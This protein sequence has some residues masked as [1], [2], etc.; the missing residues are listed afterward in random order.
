MLTFGCVKIISPAEDKD[1]RDKGKQFTTSDE[2]SEAVVLPSNVTGSYLACEVIFSKSSI[3]DETTTVG[4]RLANMV[5]LEKET[6]DPNIEWIYQSEVDGVDVMMLNVDASDPWHIHYRIHSSELRREQIMEQIEVGIQ[7][8]NSGRRFL[9]PIID[10]TEKL[11][12][13]LRGQW[14]QNDCALWFKDVPLN[15]EQ[16][17]IYRAG[18][19]DI[20]E[21][22]YT[23]YNHFYLNKECSGIPE[24][25]QIE[26]NRSKLAGF[27]GYV[28]DIDLSLDTW[29]VRPNTE[30]GVTLSEVGLASLCEGEIVTFTIGEFSDLTHC[31]PP[32]SEVIYHRIKY[33]DQGV[34]R[35]IPG[36]FN[37]PVSDKVI[38]FSP[39]F[40]PTVFLNTPENYLD[41]LA[42]FEGTY[43]YCVSHLYD[44]DGDG[45][46]V[47]P[48]STDKCRI[49]PA[50]TPAKE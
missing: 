6:L 15:G 25:E 14:N 23:D 20:T 41:R 22:L 31:F 10:T 48:S 17:N 50:R 45:W 39:D 47:I 5:S 18:I 30:T 49:L 44:D 11:N 29:K 33:L 19:S 21:D 3:Q 37:I 42:P 7:D 2:D 4:C 34:D 26:R 24:Y 9:R 8:K 28:F 43:P 40:R 12:A 27:D 36:S 32:S 16:I 35:L 13:L 38:G 46:G 1:E